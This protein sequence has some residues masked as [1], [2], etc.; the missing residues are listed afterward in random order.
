MSIIK[1]TAIIISL[2]VTVLSLK[3]QDNSI[4]YTFE[5]IQ[6]SN[7]NKLYFDIKT[8]SFL[9]NNEYFG[10]I[11][12]WTGIGFMVSPKLVY[13]AGK[14]TAV[15]AGYFLEKF[16]GRDDFYKPMPLFRIRQK[17]NK[18]LTLVFGQL[19]GNLQHRL[20]EPMF[21]FDRYYQDNVEYGIQFLFHNKY[22]DNDLWMNWEKFIFYDDPY[23]EEFVLGNTARLKFDIDKFHIRIPFHYT[24]T[25]AGGQI[26]RHDKNRGSMM[27][28]NNIMTGIKLKYV[29]DNPV[30]K[31]ISTEYNYYKYSAGANPPEGDP[32]HQLFDS[33]EGH[34]LKSNMDFGVMKM[35]L[36][37]W[38]GRDFISLRGEYLFSSIY[39]HRPDDFIRDNDLLTAK[40]IYDY[41]IKKNIV[42]SMRAD[43]YYQ[44]QTKDTY[45]S[46]AFYFIY[47]DDFL[48]YK[49]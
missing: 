23:K 33:G 7:E 46:Y 26:D 38:M 1:Y 40:F 19:Y 14:T 39:E 36:G 41:K 28:L 20:T 3:A 10:K 29:F 17:L 47:N 25:H 24:W 11:D 15:E 31:S 43:M 9:K 42:F 35:M 16:S 12:G 48:L 6:D 30:I 21:R 34:Y 44:T 4:F 49:R 8:S 32:R 22:F 18:S 27:S 45:Y 5:E 37:Y 13:Y 2:I